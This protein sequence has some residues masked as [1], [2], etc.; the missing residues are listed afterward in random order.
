MAL[1]ATPK[2]C[3]TSSLCSVDGGDSIF[4]PPAYSR[5]STGVTSVL[6]EDIAVNAIGTVSDVRVVDPAFLAVNRRLTALPS[7]EIARDNEEQKPRGGLLRALKKAFHPQ[8]AAGEKQRLF[9]PRIAKPL[10]KAQGPYRQHRYQYGKQYSFTVLQNLHADSGRLCSTYLALQAPRGQRDTRLRVVLRIYDVEAPR[11]EETEKKLVQR[12]GLSDARRE[13]LVYGRL[14]D[15]HYSS[16][17]YLLDAFGCLKSGECLVFVMPAQHCDLYQVLSG[18]VDLPAGIDRATLSRAWMAQLVIGLNMLHQLGQLKIGDYSTALVQNE[19]MPLVSGMKYGYRPRGTSNYRA[20]EVDL[21]KAHRYYTRE[22]PDMDADETNS[23]GR[24]V[25]YGQEVDTWSLGC[26]AAEILRSQAGP[27]QVLFDNDKRRFRYMH[28]DRK[29][30]FGVLE[31][32][33][34]SN[35]HLCHDFVHSLLHP[36]PQ[37]RLPLDKVPQHRFFTMWFK[38]ASRFPNG[39]RFKNFVDL[40]AYKPFRLEDLKHP[41]RYDLDA[42]PTPGYQ[43]RITAW[44]NKPNT[45]NT[46]LSSF[47]DLPWVN[48]EQPLN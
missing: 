29:I 26:V 39:K 21:Q 35:N 24:Y 4:E 33:I 16:K 2:S 15:L 1:P 20:P 9:F 42:A 41:A 17:H 12:T 32:F 40:A 13:R 25:G 37:L 28:N 36:D 7:G 38:E 27:Y 43:A 31:A 3:S 45:N 6:E 22:F 46:M 10:T 44:A 11:K 18:K 23:N 19:N 14:G 8:V 34:Q 30:Q 5:R 47:E 48:P